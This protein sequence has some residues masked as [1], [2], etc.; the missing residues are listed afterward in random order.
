MD[1]RA[2]G[3]RGFPILSLA[4]GLGLL[5]A[6]CG[7]AGSPSA[8]T[9][10]DGGT[11]TPDA[12]DRT[13]A[14]SEPA[15][16]FPT[17]LT[18]FNVAEPPTL[19]S[20]RG[21]TVLLDFW[22]AGCIN[23]QHIIPDLKRLEE[24]YADS[25]VV[26]GVHSG[27]YATEH[28]DDTVREAIGRYD[29]Q[30][31]VVND[32]DFVVW[33][34]YGA[35]AWP[36]LVLIDPA[37]NYVGTHSGEG[38]YPLFQPIIEA[39]EGEF[40]GRINSAPFPI[41]L[42]QTAASTLLSYPAAVLA[43]EQGDRLY[44]ADSGHNRILEARLNGALLR[45]FGTGA[46][47]FA[48]GRADE[49]QFFDPQGLELSADRSQLYVADT[50]NHALRAIDLKT[51]AVT[52]LAGTGKRAQALPRPG[53]KPKETALASPW[54]LLLR[55]GVLYIANAGTHQLWSYDVGADELAVYAGTS[56]EGIDDGERLTMATLAQPSGLATD[57]R[58][59]Y[60]VDP[61]SSSVR[62]T[63]FDG[64]IVDTMVGTGLFDYGDEDGTGLEAQIQHPQGIAYLDGLLY[65][66]DTYNNKIRS[67]DPTSFEVKTVA[68]TGE[69]RW[70]DGGPDEA[71]FAEPAGI[72]V[73]G[74]RLLIADTA[75]H[76]LRT[77]DPASGETGTLALSNIGVLTGTGAGRVLR[78]ELPG[79]SVAPGAT[80]LRLK[81]STPGGYH[82]NSLAP[83][84][85]TLAAVNPAVVSL[86]ETSI[87][88]STDDESVEIPI[89]VILETGTTTVTATG[90][91]YFCADGEEALC[92]IQQLEIVV[93]VEVGP[94][95]TGGELVVEYRL[96]PD[97]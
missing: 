28:E 26:I 78:V 69:N 46:A 67:I 27:K 41:V 42:D 15:P 87:S 30:H 16:E 65:I 91:A 32:P 58:Y 23:C 25:L 84:T 88:W 71:S 24:E 49:A 83:S 96:E 86:G 95:A 63:P 62:R 85:L 8:T 80:N 90:A 74:D 22:T 59:L 29:L 97:A 57:G 40:E 47:G 43:D 75:N 9:T 2:R 68:G 45:V 14:G 48:D 92:L 17:G 72:A 5:F 53:D 70:A 81:L 18:W 34:T 3:S 73:Y 10:A 7:G 13:W 1:W 44:I 33:N 51:G 19:A 6:A 76:V 66:A 54:G 60:W 35:R 38:V 21:K 56:R 12:S 31:P 36:T 37:G 55:D 11:A 79:Q 89:P 4:L 82:L 77:F 20:L 39:L 61:E 94:D 50:R 93:P 64:E 52:T